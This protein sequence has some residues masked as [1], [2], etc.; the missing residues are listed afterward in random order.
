MS[1]IAT[2]CP[3]LERV[4]AAVAPLGPAPTINASNTHALIV[5]IEFRSGF[6]NSQYPLVNCP[7]HEL[8]S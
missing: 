6:S 1:I 3:S 5:K 2:E 7:V 8:E 4:V